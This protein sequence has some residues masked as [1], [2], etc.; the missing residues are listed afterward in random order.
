MVGSDGKDSN[1]TITNGKKRK[2]KKCHRMLTK[3][4]NGQFDL[5]LRRL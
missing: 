4:K 2:K 3:N 5:D 1:N